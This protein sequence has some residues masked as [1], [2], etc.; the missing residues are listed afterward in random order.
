[1]AGPVFSIVWHAPTH[2]QTERSADWYW[3]LGV[4][5]L[6]GS[7]LAIFF[8]NLLFAAIIVL[9]AVS[10]G[11]LAVKEPRMCEIEVNER[12]VRIETSLYPYRSLKSFAID[13]DSRER[14]QLILM[15]SSFLNPELVL[16]L[17]DHVNPEDVRDVLLTKLEE[18][19]HVESLFSR[20]ADLAG[21]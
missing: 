6:V 1:M 10:I 5:A 15:T 4:L 12:G 3:A 9:S 20:L 14:P 7:V 17:G 8:G 13:E 18:G 21:I 2:E 19:E 11:I 16:P